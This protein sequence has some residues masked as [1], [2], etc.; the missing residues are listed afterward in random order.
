VSTAAAVVAKE[1][2]SEAIP[3]CVF[4]GILLLAIDGPAVLLAVVDAFDDPE[5]PIQ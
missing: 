4:M 1:M 5:T 2:Q 3:A